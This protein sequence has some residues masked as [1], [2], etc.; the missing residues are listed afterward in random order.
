MD[1]KQH[2]A[3]MEKTVCSFEATLG[4]KRL[5]VSQFK[6]LLLA[7]IISYFWHGFKSTKCS[8]F[9]GIA[10]MKRFHNQVTFHHYF[11]YIVL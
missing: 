4:D 5:N 2:W 6:L 1:F 9:K 11:A 3:Y 7:I 10:V 8:E